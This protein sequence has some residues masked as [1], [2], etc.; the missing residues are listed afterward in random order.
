MGFS[1]A[2]DLG[3]LLAGAAEPDMHVGILHTDLLGEI[4]DLKAG[5][6]GGFEGGENLLLDLATW[7]PLAGAL[8]GTASFFGFGGATYLLFGRAATALAGGADSLSAQKGREL[9]FDFF[10][11]ADQA[12]LAFREFDKALKCRAANVC[13]IGRA[14]V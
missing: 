8:G 12:F 10:D 13:K 7:S 11:L 5:V 14:H 9:R 4:S 3:K 2:F 1:D 6:T